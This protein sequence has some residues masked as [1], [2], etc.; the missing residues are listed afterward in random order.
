[1][2]DIASQ[3]AIMVLGPLA[4]WMVGWKN[5]YRK[6]GYLVGILSQPFWFI[7]LY[8]NKQWPV[9]VC[10]FLYTYSWANGFYNFVSKKEK[11]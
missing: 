8:N 3:Y 6:W 1:M 4:V 5:K 9:F 11:L 10:A 7:T 2:I